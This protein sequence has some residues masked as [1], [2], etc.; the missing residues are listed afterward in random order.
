MFKGQDFVGIGGGYGLNI[1]D[2]SKV[3]PAFGIPYYGIDSLEN[4]CD[5]INEVLN[6]EGPAFCEVFVDW[7]QN[8][9]PKSSSKVLPSGQ[10]VSAAIDDMAPFI[11]RLEYENNHL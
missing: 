9:A 11:D 3:I 5:R 6:V 4:I 10:I 1:P 7:H 2:F 8:F